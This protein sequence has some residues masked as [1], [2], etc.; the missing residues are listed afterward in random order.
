MVMANKESN[1]NTALAKCLLIEEG[2]LPCIPSMYSHAK[3]YIFCQMAGWC[4]ILFENKI[5]WS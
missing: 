5:C 2:K 3:F 4:S 1:G